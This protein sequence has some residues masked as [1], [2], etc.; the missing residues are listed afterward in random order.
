MPPRLLMV[1]LAVCAVSC[2]PT[3]QAKAPPPQPLR[4][5]PPSLQDLKDGIARRARTYSDGQFKF[6]AR[7]ANAGAP[8]QVIAEYRYDLA[9]AG[10]KVRLER[11]TLEGR[12]KGAVD[13]AAWDGSRRKGYR[14]MPAAPPQN[15]YGGTIVDK[16]DAFVQRQKF[17]SVTHDE[18]P[19]RNIPLAD[20]V[21]A[22]T[23][24]LIG[25]RLVGGVPAWGIRNDGHVG[26]A[27]C[28]V[29]VWV[30][31]DRGFAPVEVSEVSRG[32]D[33]K[34]AGSTRLTDVE[35]IRRDDRWVFR[36]ARVVTTNRASSGEQVETLELTDF[37]A[38]VPK[39]FE[40]AV[41]F[42]VG[43]SVLDLARPERRVF[44]AGKCVLI[45]G[46]AGEVRASDLKRFPE[47]VAMTDFS[48]G[49]SDEEY[50]STSWAKAAAEPE[51]K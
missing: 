31:P 10:A 14:E 21:A 38:G 48:T 45:R 1:V 18:L 22:G 35:L 23:W 3:E 24:A 6:T 28:D 36:K 29:E 49:L 20:V 17:R 30:C 42:P 32:R 39:D 11:V 4:P 5:A 25:T 2:R 41:R 43:T 19:S 40:F 27:S 12:A 37:A 51:P 15:R 47:Y 44:I 50:A 13:R 33:G 26:Q 8:E 46:A 9:K 16:I 34:P 7:V